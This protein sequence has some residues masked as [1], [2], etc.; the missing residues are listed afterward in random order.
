M[1]LLP[2]AC[3]ADESEPNDERSTMGLDWLMGG[4]AAFLVLVYGHF[5]FCSHWGTGSERMD[6]VWCRASWLADSGGTEE[7]RSLA[8]QSHIECILN[9]VG[10]SVVGL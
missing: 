7:S 5:F 3:M 9:R 6:G 1:L 2:A 4:G 10:C 8:S